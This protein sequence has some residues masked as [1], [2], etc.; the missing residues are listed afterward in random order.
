MIHKKTSSR[1]TRLATRLASTLPMSLLMSV[2]APALAGDYSV[3]SGN[4]CLAHHFR[5]QSKIETDRIVVLEDGQVVCRLQRDNHRRTK[6]KSLKANI[7][8]GPSTATRFCYVQGIAA[9]HSTRYVST[10]SF[11]GSHETVTPRIENARLHR[12]GPMLLLCSL[13]KG[14]SVRTVIYEE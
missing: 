3:I 6:L 13:K 8:L 1:M 5:G 4:D 12:N 2:G 9:D 10:N 14:D 11:S 7:S